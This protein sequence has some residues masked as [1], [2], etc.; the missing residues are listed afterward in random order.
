MNE[1]KINNSTLI[2]SPDIAEAFNVHFTNTGPNLASE[3]PFF[4]IP[5]ENYLT[6]LNTTFS[7]RNTSV[8]KVRQLLK[9]RRK[10]GNW[11]G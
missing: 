10:K 11:I 9:K 4:D 8:N 6:P 5:P 1:I 2:S 7:L 3:I